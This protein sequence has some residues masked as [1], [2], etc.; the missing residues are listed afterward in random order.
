MVRSRQDYHGGGQP[1]QRLQNDLFLNEPV[2]IVSFY[3]SAR[4]VEKTHS[5]RDAIWQLK[6]V[7]K[8]DDFSYYQNNKNTFQLMKETES[9][10]SL[11]FKC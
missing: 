9:E 7:M 3:V 10:M 8:F 1:E 4:S 6:N 2:K 5:S 11:I